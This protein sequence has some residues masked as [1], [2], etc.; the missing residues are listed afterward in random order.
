MPT[1]DAFILTR[2]WRDSPK[3]LVY[4]LWA[5][6]NEGPVRIVVDGGE[7]VCFVIRSARLYRS[8]LWPELA[9]FGDEDASLDERV[10]L[11][12]EARGAQ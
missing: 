2:Q 10:I 4:E 6:S 12:R 8:I 7:A 3:G 9:Q 1:V 11:W 5:A